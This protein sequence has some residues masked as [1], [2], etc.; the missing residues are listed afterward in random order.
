MSAS[1]ACASADEGSARERLLEALTRRAQAAF[2]ALA[3]VEPALQA[4]MEGF[5][6]QAGNLCR[7]R[8]IG[9]GQLE[10]IH[11]RGDDL[12][13]QVEEVF[14]LQLI[15]AAPERLVVFAAVPRDVD[16][17]TLAP[18]RHLAGE[19]VVG[20]EA[21]PDAREVAALR[22]RAQRQRARQHTQAGDAGQSPDE[23]VHQAMAEVLEL[24]PPLL[25]LGL[26]GDDVVG[27]CFVADD[28]VGDGLV[29]CDLEWDDGNG[30][31]GQRLRGLPW[32]LATTRG[33]R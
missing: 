4:Q 31:H 2:V 24:A 23:L 5:P 13:A 28:L 22:P 11:D 27:D 16:R 21:P 20:M 7:R 8:G 26:V 10:R 18:G 6:V 1:P 12:V 19:D 29:A 15:V 17:E 32:A 14:D 3:P 33:A 30:W 9:G 25:A